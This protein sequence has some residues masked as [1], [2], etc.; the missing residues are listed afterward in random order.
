MASSESE[1][2]IDK[3][4]DAV[5]KSIKEISAQFFEMVPVRKLK[6]KVI[7]KL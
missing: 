6:W 4:C 5:S 7:K 1:D 2:F 3:N